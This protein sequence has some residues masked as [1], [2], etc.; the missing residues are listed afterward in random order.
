MKCCTKCHKELPDSE[1]YKANWI[2][3]GIR[4]DCKECTKKARKIYRN[5]PK[6]KL[7]ASEYA[8]AYIKS[9]RSKQVARE[10]R[11]NHPKTTE[12]K[13][14][15]VSVVLSY[16][17]TPEGKANRARYGAKRRSSIELVPCTLTSDEWKWIKT[18]YKNK[19]AYCGEKKKLTMDHIIPI[20]KGG[21][22]TIGNIVPACQSCNAQK[23][24]KLMSPPVVALCW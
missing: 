11:Q 1:F 3:S 6:G 21:H 8:K 17:K 16:F 20:S 12:A 24:T 15:R 13:A 5:T 23:G 9:G 2:E 7:K 18:K 22:H 14:A 10:H 4:P 19:C